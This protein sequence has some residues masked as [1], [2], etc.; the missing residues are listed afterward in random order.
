MWRDICLGNRS[1]ILKEL[2]QYLAITQHMR[3]LIA[4]NNGAGLEKLFK[5]ASQA[6]QD[7]D[8]I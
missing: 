4:E 2:D 5:K 3:N 6:R 7:M 1:S 8:V